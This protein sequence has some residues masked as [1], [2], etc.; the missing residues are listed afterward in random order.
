LAISFLRKIHFAPKAGV[1]KIT[2]LLDKI[3]DVNSNQSG[4]TL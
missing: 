3:V 1:R 2:N 4:A